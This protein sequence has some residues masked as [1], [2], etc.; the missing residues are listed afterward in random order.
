MHHRHLHV[1]KE[2]FR[3]VVKA[4]DSHRNFSNCF[5][6]NIPSYLEPTRAMMY[7]MNHPY[8]SLFHP[9]YPCTDVVF[10][11]N[12]SPPVLLICPFLIL[13]TIQ[14]G[15]THHRFLLFREKF[16][17]TSSLTSWE[18][19]WFTSNMSRQQRSLLRSSLDFHTITPRNQDYTMRPA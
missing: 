7:K 9:K 8:R 15:L 5:N 3:L 2:L 14:L 16:K 1:D 19:G 18:T 12:L 10:Q 4:T 17:I 6:Q 13:T 11:S